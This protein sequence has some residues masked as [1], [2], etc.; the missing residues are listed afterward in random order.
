[1]EVEVDL[2]HPQQTNKGGD[3]QE[4]K[5]EN[6]NHVRPPKINF[7]QPIKHNQQ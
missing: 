2:K 6:P 5:P 7:N 3:K 4:R 1:M